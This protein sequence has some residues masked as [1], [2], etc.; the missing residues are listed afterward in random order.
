MADGV[1]Y[2][3]CWLILSKGQAKVGRTGNIAQD[4]AISCHSEV[5]AHCF[6]R[7]CCSVD[8]ISQRCAKWPNQGP[9]YVVVLLSSSIDC[10]KQVVYAMEELGQEPMGIV[11]T[12]GQVWLEHAEVCACEHQEQ[13]QIHKCGR[14]GARKTS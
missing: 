4:G 6:V 8:T 2:S 3:F 9:S 11:H 1:I 7:N 13:Q 14:L 5:I 12:P 10:C